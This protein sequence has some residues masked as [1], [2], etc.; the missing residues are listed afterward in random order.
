MYWVHVMHW[1]AINS[2]EKTSLEFVRICLQMWIPFYQWK[3]VNTL[4]ASLGQLMAIK[5]N[6]AIVEELALRP[7]Y[8]Y[9][10]KK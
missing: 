2:D 1:T 6:A 3:N 10:N 5:R 7:Q 8:M 4:L 9:I